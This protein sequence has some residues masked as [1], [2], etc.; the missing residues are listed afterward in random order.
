MKIK[1]MIMITTKKISTHLAWRRFDL[2][3]MLSDREIQR[4]D[5]PLVRGLRLRLGISCKMKVHTLTNI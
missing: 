5:G 3:C 4:I 1:I 2:K